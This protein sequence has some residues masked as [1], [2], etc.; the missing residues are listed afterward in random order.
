[1]TIET[2]MH[3]EL[4][5]STLS[6]ETKRYVERT[7][8]AFVQGQ[9]SAVRGVALVYLLRCSGDA[10]AAMLERLSDEEFE[11]LQ[12]AVQREAEARS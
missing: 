11:H 12:R 4:R 8:H 2:D 9:G 7:L 5:R 3:P 1:M 6:A 10:G